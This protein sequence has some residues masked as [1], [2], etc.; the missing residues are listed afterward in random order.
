MQQHDVTKW[1]R[2][3]TLLFLILTCKNADIIDPLTVQLEQRGRYSGFGGVLA[4]ILFLSRCA[5]SGSS[6][7]VDRLSLVS[8]SDVNG[9][10]QASF[11]FSKRNALV[12]FSD[13]L[14]WTSTSVRPFY[15]WLMLRWLFHEYNSPSLCYGRLIVEA[16]NVYMSVLSRKDVRW[17]IQSD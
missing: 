2:I 7:A 10:D 3:S 15:A 1:R 12:L 8:D 4:T 5:S 16:G 9:A 6:G 13:R 17:I 11:S 14:L